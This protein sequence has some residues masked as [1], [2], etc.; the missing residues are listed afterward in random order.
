MPESGNRELGELAAKLDSLTTAFRD[1]RDEIRRGRQEDKEWRDL[2]DGQGENTTHKQMWRSISEA[3][4]EISHVK[5]QSSVWGT[6]GGA[7]SAALSVIGIK[8]FGG[9]NH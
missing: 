3:H 1:F 2:H 7:I 8:L 4:K 9:G 5:L 6:I